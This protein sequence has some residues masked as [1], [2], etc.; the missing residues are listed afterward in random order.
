MKKD[1]APEKQM[2]LLKKYRAEV[3]NFAN[4]VPCSARMG[5]NEN[6]AKSPGALLLAGH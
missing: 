5:E 3:L 1:E 2:L 6:A 4:D